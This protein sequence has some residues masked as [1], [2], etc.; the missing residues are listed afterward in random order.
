[1]EPIYSPQNVTPAYQLNWGLTI[2]WRQ[3]PIPHSEWL[4][5]LQ[6]ATEPDGVRILKHRTLSDNATQ[7]FISTRPH[8]SPSQLILGAGFA[9][10]PK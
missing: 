9:R 4:T 1:M 3:L 10:N 7:F 6:T 8:V 2:F 5:Q